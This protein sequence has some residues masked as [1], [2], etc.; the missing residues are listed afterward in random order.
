M[1]E[2]KNMRGRPDQKQLPPLQVV[3]PKKVDPPVIDEWRKC[4]LC[5]SGYGG[6]GVAYHT[7]GR[8]RYYKCREC[9]HRWTFDFES[10][11]VNFKMPASEE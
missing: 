2:R 5:F 9:G 8:K 4:P 6:I 10:V 3:E 7:A 1:D 11:T